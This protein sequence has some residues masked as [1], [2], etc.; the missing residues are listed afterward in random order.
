MNEL[1]EEEWD[2]EFEDDDYYDDEEEEDDVAYMVNNGSLCSFC[3]CRRPTDRLVRLKG[4]FPDGMGGR[5][6][7]M[8]TYCVDDNDCRKEGENLKSVMKPI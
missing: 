8:V 5:D 7:K 3:G 6:L 1:T 2:E 4:R